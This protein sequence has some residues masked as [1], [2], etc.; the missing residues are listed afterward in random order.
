[1]K[2]LRVCILIFCCFVVRQTSF[3]QNKKID[4][5]LAKVDNY[6]ASGDFSKGLSGLQKIKKTVSAKPDLQSYLPGLHIRE[7]RFNLALGSLSSFDNSLT[8]AMSSSLT[9]FGDNSTNYATTLIE[10]GELYNEYGNFRLSN[11]YLNRAMILLQ[12]SNQLTDALKSRIALAQSE[13][14]IGQ[15]FWND[16]IELLKENEKYFASR[17]IEKETIVAGASLKNHK[18]SRTRTT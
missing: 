4:N 15:G 12:K 10:V 16:A 2:I 1:M 3:S 5:S 14:M 13:A 8:T 11:E 9:T 18:N 17:A 7:A 6:Y